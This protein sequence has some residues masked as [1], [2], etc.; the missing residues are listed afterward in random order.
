MVN[1]LSIA[2]ITDFKAKN[3]SLKGIVL[4]WCVKD[5]NVGDSLQSF[6]WVFHENMWDFIFL[7]T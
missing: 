7:R 1:F 6:L 4:K 2:D 5:E 3:R